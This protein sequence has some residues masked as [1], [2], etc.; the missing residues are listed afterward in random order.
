M[1]AHLNNNSITLNDESDVKLS[2]KNN[3]NDFCLRG[4]QKCLF[5]QNCNVQPN[6]VLEKM[7]NKERDI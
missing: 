2:T 6:E 5:L 1:L 4:K 7:Q 3:N